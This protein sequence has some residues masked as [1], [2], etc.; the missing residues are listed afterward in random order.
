MGLGACWASK[1]ASLA[2]IE[3][4]E[5]VGKEQ[6]LGFLEYHVKEFEPYPEVLGNHRWFLSK[7]GT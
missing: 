7:R 6:M 2:R 4:W 1:K 3:C 5:P